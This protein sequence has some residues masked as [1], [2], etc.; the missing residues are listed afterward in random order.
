MYTIPLKLDLDYEQRPIG[1]VGLCALLVVAYA[2]TTHLGPA[3]VRRLAL[4]PVSYQPWQLVTAPLLHANAIHL[5]GN[6]LFLVVFGRLIDEFLG[7]WRL[8]VLFLLFA[9]LA[10]LVYLASGDRRP[11]VGAS[12]GVSGLMGL[13]LFT[14]PRVGIQTFWGLFF[15]LR[16]ATIPA[17]YLLGLFVLFDLA[18]LWAARVDGEVGVGAAAAHVGGFVAGV[19]ASL[20]LRSP[21]AEGTGW[22]LPRLENGGARVS[23]RYHELLQSEA[24]WRTIEEATRRRARGK[25]EDKERPSD[26][27]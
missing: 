26:T 17:W 19:L 21:L 22:S 6:V 1:T 15:L 10:G 27:R 4:D 25:A 18:D 3:V 11:A 9:A 23:N 24:M 20:L 16:R 14:A 8:L 7:G 2:V 12:G 13:V 5:L